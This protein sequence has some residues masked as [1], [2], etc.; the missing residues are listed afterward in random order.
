MLDLCKCGSQ[1]AIK[2]SNSDRH[3]TLCW[4]CVP[5][6]A[7]EIIAKLGNE[8]TRHTEEAIGSTEGGRCSDGTGS[9]CGATPL[10]GA[11]AP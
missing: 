7:F 3:I 6:H 2:L 10:S 9:D 4:D 1:G 5:P 8:G 11:K